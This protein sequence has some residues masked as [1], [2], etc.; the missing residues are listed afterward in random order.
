MI[1]GRDKVSY[2]RRGSHLSNSGARLISGARGG[3]KKLHTKNIEPPKSVEFPCQLNN[4]F[5]KISGKNTGWRLMVPLRVQHF[6]STAKVLRRP[7]CG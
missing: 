3:N 2:F 4:H 6:L 5:Q 1:W 7:S